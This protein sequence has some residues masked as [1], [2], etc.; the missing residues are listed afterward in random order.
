MLDFEGGTM[1]RTMQ[2]PSEVG[3]VN[4]SY[5]Q[6]TRLV[7]FILKFLFYY[8]LVQFEQ[9]FI[10]T[11][12]NNKAPQRGKKTMQNRKFF[13]SKTISLLQVQQKNNDCS[14]KKQILKSLL[15]KILD[16]KRD[17][18]GLLNLLH[19]TLNNPYVVLKM[20]IPA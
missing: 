8:I 16:T 18:R 4:L 1:V 6:T 20:M 13:G 17:N 19:F 12:K 3:T 11:N 5:H 15:H 10:S 14:N 2:K 7:N 9:T